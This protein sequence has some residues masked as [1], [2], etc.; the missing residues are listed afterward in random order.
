MFIRGCMVSSQFY[1]RRHRG[2]LKGDPLCYVKQCGPVP[3]LK[4]KVSR[5]R[6]FALDP[7]ETS[8]IRLIHSYISLFRVKLCYVVSGMV[9]SVHVQL[10][11]H[12]SN[13][14]DMSV[15]S[16]VSFHFLKNV[17]MGTKTCKWSHIIIFLKVEGSAGMPTNLPS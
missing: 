14:M 10:Q 12:M 6:A 9:I 2:N 13:R 3:F 8:H 7:H 4:R 1:T 17:L 5:V 15:D 11:I 16:Y